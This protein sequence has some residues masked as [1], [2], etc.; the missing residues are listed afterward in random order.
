MPTLQVDGATIAYEDTGSPDGRP[1]APTIFFGHGLLF[2]GWMFHPQV[3]AL[4]DEYR[5]VT[6]DW[7]GQGDSPPATGGGYAMDTLYADAVALVEHLDVGPVHYVGLSMGGFVGQRIAARRGELLRS[8]TLL[9]T[10]PDREPVKSAVEDIAMAAIYRYAGMRPL[11]KAVIK[12]MFGPTFRDDPTNRPVIDEFIQRLGR[13]DRAG[14]RHAIVAVAT[15]KPVYPELDRITVPTQVITG[16][17]D[18]P[19]PPAKGRRIA[20]R[21]PGAR[22]AIVPQCGHSSTVEQPET[23]TRLIGEFI[24]AVDAG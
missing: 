17:D 19:T 14:M 24:R 13:C 18:T 15:R 7:R 21:I 16:A 8:L 9:D 2:S 12:I 6:V 10:S 3:E 4:S 23:I 11:E 20:D 5:C 1:D 22:L